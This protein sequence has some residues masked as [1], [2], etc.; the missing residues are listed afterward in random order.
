MYGRGKVGYLKV[1]ANEIGGVYEWDV[2]SQTQT[3]AMVMETATV[4][5][6]VVENVW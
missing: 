6:F 2:S 4:Q 1:N 3:L 5:N